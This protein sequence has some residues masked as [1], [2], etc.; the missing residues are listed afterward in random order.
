MLCENRKKLLTVILKR[1][2]C[3]S[4]VGDFDSL[5]LTTSTCSEKIVF[6]KF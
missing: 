4:S 3:F 2:F 5:E 1:L 6:S